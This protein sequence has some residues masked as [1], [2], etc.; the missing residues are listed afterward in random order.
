MFSAANIFTLGLASDSG[1]EHVNPT[2]NEVLATTDSQPTGHYHA[3]VTLT[4]CELDDSKALF[5]IQ[6][7]NNAD[8]ENNILETLIVAV[9]VDSSR[10]FEVAFELNPDERIT[11]IPYGNGFN[12]RCMAAI[13]WQRVS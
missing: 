7:R 9:P 6:H 11:V 10:Q 3:L 8:E 1:G 4:A 2:K 5:E 13:N 12:G